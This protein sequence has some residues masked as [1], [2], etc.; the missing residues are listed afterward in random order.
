[1]NNIRISPSRFAA[2]MTQ[3]RGKE[4]F[5]ATFY[6]LAEQIAMEALGVELPDLKTF[7]IQWGIEHEFEAVMAYE[8]RTGRSVDTVTERLIHPR[9]A[10]VT[11]EPDG[12]IGADGG[13]E[14]K[15]PNSLN[16][17]KNIISG[18]QI[19]DY[20]PQMQG[21]M[22][23]TGRNWFD[24]VSFDPRF[25][26]PQ[27]QLAIHR[28]ERDADFIAALEPRVVKLYETINEILTKL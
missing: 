2:V 11:G 18:A 8:E 1:M 17:F 10:F 15:C 23:I 19:K 4:E 21:Y 20:Y 13:I 27:H 22:W 14:V 7:E 9:F 12:L 5:G 28:V 26:N 25:P 3:G 24:F 16:H 6:S